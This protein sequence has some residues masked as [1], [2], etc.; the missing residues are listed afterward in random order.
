MNSKKFTDL[1][2]E[3]LIKLML[4]KEDPI[5]LPMNNGVYLKMH[6]NIIASI[7]NIEVKKQPKWTKSWI[8]LERRSHLQK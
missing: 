2:K 3:V 6:D 1:R 8:F 7:E 5:E 4:K